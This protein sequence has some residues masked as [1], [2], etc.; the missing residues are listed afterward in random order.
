MK[1]GGE[2][3]ARVGRA[4]ERSWDLFPRGQGA[5]GGLGA[6]QRCDLIL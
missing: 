5:A 2:G 3:E 4:L 1:M 6:G